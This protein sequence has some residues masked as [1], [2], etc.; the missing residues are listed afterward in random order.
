MCNFISKLQIIYS[1]KT[2]RRI[3]TSIRTTS[4]SHLKY[5]LYPETIENL[6]Y[7]KTYT[8]TFLG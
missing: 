5:F 7:I 3:L 6:L 8:Q 4:Y 1:Y 2:Y